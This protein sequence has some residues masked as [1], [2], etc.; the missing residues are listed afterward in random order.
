MFNYREAELYCEGVR[1]ADVA[2]QVGT[3]VYVYSKARIE[4]NYKAVA[5]AFAQ[6]NPLI[7]YAVK[8]NSNLAV[9]TLLRDLD[10]GFDVVSG[11]ELHRVMSIAADPQRVAFAG[12][13]K[14]EREMVYALECQV[15]EINIESAQELEALERLA[16]GNGHP[17]RVALRVN[18]G[19]DPHTHHHI[20]TGHAGSK[21]GIDVE[22]IPAVLQQA[23]QYTHT[24][25]EG[26]HIH[27]GSQI[28]TPQPF[29]EA[30]H[31]LLDLVQQARGLGV[32]I[33]ALDIG[34]G[35]PMAYREGETAA[36]LDH[37]A[38]AIVPL[39]QGTGLQVRVEPGR[40]IVA[41]AG[42]LLAQVQFVKH[43][44]GRRIAV[45]DAGMN[46]LI[47]PALYEAY[48]TI[49]P[50]TD[51]QQTSDQQPA[52]SN[53][54]TDIA[55]PICESSD[56]LGRER[57]LPSVQRGDILAVLNAGAYGA[58][59]ASNYNSQPRPPEV[60]VEGNTFRVVRRRE[61][62]NDL[63]QFELT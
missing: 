11:G 52:T 58:T 44:A 23:A 43:S 30:L 22:Q 57:I 16:A 18:P 3:P 8:A 17:A 28:P 50:I 25:V 7:C 19:I 61:T 45:T 48:H 1:L 38:R 37:F 5:Q 56:Y 39:L 35:F 10:S 15:G 6:I 32:T 49:I 62:W 4:E 59:M 2:A 53:E 60:L 12:A 9:L 13:G 54:L 24:R 41:D 21:F 14:T 51:Q 55:G 36:P 40:R 46:T 42:V 47:R 29:V 20:S 31:K 27:I 63:T 34:G 33:N 26:L